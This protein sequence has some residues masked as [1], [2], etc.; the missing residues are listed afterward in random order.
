MCAPSVR[1]DTQETTVKCELMTNYI[2]VFITVLFQS[3]FI[4]HSYYYFFEECIRFEYTF[5]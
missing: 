1:K 5:V 2:E 4:V 3:P